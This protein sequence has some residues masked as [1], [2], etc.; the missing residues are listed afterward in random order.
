M[1]VS[2]F[3]GRIVADPKVFESENGNKSCRFSLAVKRD[4][5]TGN[6]QADFIDFI[7]YNQTANYI[8]N[9]AK[10]GMQVEI[11]ASFRTFEKKGNE[12]AT[13]PE[14]GYNFLVDKFEILSTKEEMKNY[15][16]KEQI[17]DMPNRKQTQKPKLE[18]DNSGYKLFNDNDD[19]SKF[20]PF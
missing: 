15:H 4:F 9:Y 18:E 14:K 3:V 7:A 20:I 17:E 10:K 11:R 12:P 8:G 5:A 6:N 19:L 2:L 1:N 16:N 13:K